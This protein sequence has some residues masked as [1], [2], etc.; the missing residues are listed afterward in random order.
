MTSFAGLA[1]GTSAAAYQTTTSAA[2]LPGGASMAGTSVASSA[3]VD[4]TVAGS[5]D[6][7]KWPNYIH[8]AAGGG[9]I[10]TYVKA[11]AAAVQSYANDQRTLMW[12]DGASTPSGSDQA[13]LSVSGIG[14]GFQITAPADTTSRTLSVYIGGSN[15]GGALIA[16]LSDGSAPDYVST[17]VAVTGQYDLVYTITYRAASAGQQLSVGWTHISGSG[18]V[19]LQGAALK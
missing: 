16:H 8:K 3:T 5:A 13:G 19:R 4:L 10:S 17:T 6:W 15:S 11:G 14:S 18:N 7:A 2:T 1:Q 12:S 9:Q